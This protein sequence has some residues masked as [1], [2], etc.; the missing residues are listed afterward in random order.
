MRA[1]QRREGFDSIDGCVNWTTRVAWHEVQ[2]EW[3]RQA[4]VTPGEIPDL[5]DGRDPAR[6]TEARLILD[7]TKRILDTL[8]IDDRKAIL[9][10]LDERGVSEGRLTAREKMRRHRARQRLAVL[11]ET[12]SSVEMRRGSTP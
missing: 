11:L 2:A 8:K 3:Y 1:L 7:A 9:S 5:A 12:D 10:V 6:V 4:R